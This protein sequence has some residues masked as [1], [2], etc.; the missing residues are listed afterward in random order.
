[1]NN[2][3][4][5][6]DI[7]AA[8]MENGST[9]E[10][11]K[12]NLR[13]KDALKF[14]PYSILFKPTHNC[15]IRCAY[16]YD[17]IAQVKH[18]KGIMSVDRARK[19]IDMIKADPRP[20]AMFTFHGGE[21]LMAGI[22]WYKKILPYF[23]K[24]IP[25]VPLS[26]QSNGILLT[27]EF[28][29][30]FKEY[31]LPVGLS[32]DLYPDDL[33]KER[34]YRQNIPLKKLQMLVEYD[35]KTKPYVLNGFISV[36]SAENYKDLVSA[37]KKAKET[38]LYPSLN[39][40]FPTNEIGLRGDAFYSYEEYAEE[41]RKLLFYYVTE[42]ED[43]Q[44]ERSI[45][46]LTSM[47][48]GGCYSCCNR[49]NC[50]YGWVGIGPNGE[51]A[52]CDTYTYGK[53]YLGTIDDY[54]HITDMQYTDNYANIARDKKLKRLTNCSRC[55]LS[56]ICRGTCFANSLNDDGD[57]MIFDSNACNELHYGLYGLYQIYRNH[58][59]FSYMRPGKPNPV[60][61]QL[62][63]NDFYTMW[64]INEVI[65]KELDVD[66]YT[67][68]PHANDNPYRL[69]E[70][71][72]FQIFRIFNPSEAVDDCLAEKVPTNRIVLYNTQKHFSSLIPEEAKE[73]EIQFGVLNVQK[74]FDERRMAIKYGLVENLEKIK[75]ILNK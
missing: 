25:D 17:R 73:K 52:H 40:L 49:R 32:Y 7:C 5:G 26:M 55:P 42:C 58:N 57:G 66:L 59:V 64:E 69:F 9:G 20:C 28:I 11:P 16:C 65:K 36:I 45:S 47:L 46:H 4:Q 1:M 24:Q 23:K 56:D 62:I 74:I 71:K 19:V 29:D 75:E 10:K 31:N 33:P 72:E 50:S 63:L 67:L 44:V 37:V 51:L 61:M 43:G 18:G 54:E 48:H 6:C 39:F 68:D 35:H 8:T 12:L 21:P 14:T 53:Y 22:E 15:N 34:R 38:G 2:T 3:C 27:K 60:Q 13:L 41:L 70:S 30:L